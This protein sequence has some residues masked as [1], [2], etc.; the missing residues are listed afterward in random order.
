M[1]N[2]N[3]ALGEVIKRQREEKGWSLTELAERTDGRI[4]RSYI[5]RLEKGEKKNPSWEVV[6]KLIE[7]LGINLRELLQLYNQDEILK[8]EFEQTK[9]IGIREVLRMNNLYVKFDEDEQIELNMREKEKLADIN[10]QI[11]NSSYSQQILENAISIIGEA[12]E[13]QDLFRLRRQRYYI[14]E[15]GGTQYNIFWDNIIRDQMRE[16]GIDNK[17]LMINLKSSLLE[18]MVNEGMNEL[19][20]QGGNVFLY[21]KNVYIK[22]ISLSIIR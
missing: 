17:R 12:K 3:N 19:Y 6:L 9:K 2:S 16:Y 1:V 5:F 10:E 11:L 20:F 7:V 13:L 8:R 15:I 14:E 18:N 4:E 21:K 22:F